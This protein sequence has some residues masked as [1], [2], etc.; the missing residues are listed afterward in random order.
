MFAVC[1]NYCPDEN[2]REG[3]VPASTRDLPPG[4]A[5]ACANG[6]RHRHRRS[7]EP[8]SGIGPYGLCRFGAFFGRSGGVAGFR[9]YAST[10]LN[11]SLRSDDRSKIYNRVTLG[12]RLNHSARLSRII[13]ASV[14]WAFFGG[15]MTRH[16]SD[17]RLPWI[18][19]AAIVGLLSAAGEASAADK[20]CKC[21]VKQGC[22]MGCC[23]QPG[24]RSAA[25]TAMPPVA[26]A[27]VR[28]DLTSLPADPCACRSGEPAEPASEPETPASDQDQAGSVGLPLEP[29]R[30]AV[31]TPVSAPASGLSRAPLLLNTTRLLI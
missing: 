8:V 12:L 11:N 29:S 28:V 15:S 9:E 2:R 5:T 21:C 4:R 18:A 1:Y 7:D 24:T 30:L 25:E 16:L 3:G 20:A 6:S 22:S 13:L 14:R 19:L 26:V 31:F 10:N 23:G 27:L 17:I